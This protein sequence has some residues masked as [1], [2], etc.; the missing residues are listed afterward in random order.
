MA[1]IY[2]GIDWDRPDV[3]TP[4][5]AASRRGNEGSMRT[6]VGMS[7]NVNA[8]PKDYFGMTA[9]QGAANHGNLEVVRFLVEKGA[10]INDAPAPIG[11]MTALQAAVHGMSIQVVHFLLEHGA[12]INAE[13]AE[14]EGQSVLLAAINTVD[15][16]LI[17]FLVNE[18]ADVNP[19]SNWRYG[20]TALEA[21]VRSG[22]I[23]LVRLL[24]V[25]HAE[26]LFLVVGADA[27]AYDIVKLFLDHGADVNRAN[28]DS[29][30]V[31]E[32]TVRGNEYC[33]GIIQ[34]LFE[35][36]ANRMDALPAVARSG[37]LD[38]AEFLLDSDVDVNAARRLALSAIAEAARA[39][40]LDMVR[41][42]LG[43]GANDRSGALIGAVKASHLALARLLV[44]T[45]VDVNARPWAHDRSVL[46]EAA[47]QG[48]LEITRLLLDSGADVE[49]TEDTSA[50]TTRISIR[51]IALQ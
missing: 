18:G 33:L 46:E 10:F 34:L 12:D 27:A 16:Y 48:N 31:I 39:G 44:R 28:K 24:L 8:A 30:T 42:F 38:L 40:D 11:G 35:H 13:I 49:D 36:G 37:D 20:H 5:Q 1:P 15:M 26:S 4:L 25:C 47:L 51:T 7:A 14:E 2:E 45:G 50:S 43:Y 22:N 19:V 21:A 29:T 41:L 9:F 6:L 23:E 3:E 17:Q 32:R